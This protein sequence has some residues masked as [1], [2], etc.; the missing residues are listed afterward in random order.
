MLDI[1]YQSLRSGRHDAGQAVVEFALSLA[2]LLLLIFGVVEGGRVLHGWITLQNAA[3]EGGRYA[4]TGQYEESCLSDVPACP[5][6]RIWSIDWVARGSK[7]GGKI[8]KASE[9]SCM[10]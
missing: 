5:D 9:S 7:S 1:G 2:V 3:R 6:A 4:I 8:P 10:A